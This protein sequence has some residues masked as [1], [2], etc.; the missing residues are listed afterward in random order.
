[1][2]LCPQECLEAER[3]EPLLPQLLPF[4][5]P[6]RRLLAAPLAITQFEK[7]VGAFGGPGETARWRELRARLEVSAAS[8]D[9]SVPSNGTHDVVL[10]GSDKQS[11]SGDGGMSSSAQAGF[12]RNGGSSSSSSS[13]RGGSGGSSN[14]GGPSASNAS[15]ISSSSSNS[16]SSGGLAQHQ[17][18]LIAKLPKLTALQRA[19]FALGAGEMAVTLTANGAAVRS[20]AQEG[21]RIEAF[22]H[23]PVWL[24][25]T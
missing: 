21:V 7:L 14:G 23:R 13:S 25:G 19:V 16:S 17:A 3:Q 5:G 15:C 8:S 20:A 22:V 11:R 6:G 1:M 4:I 12:G 2:P 24:T 9:G 10:L 18:A